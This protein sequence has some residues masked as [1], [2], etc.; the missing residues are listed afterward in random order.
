MFVD[1]LERD[2]SG[3]LSAVRELPFL[4]TFFLMAIA[5][6]LEQGTGGG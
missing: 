4:V 6:S 3:S 2:A 1:G 5:S